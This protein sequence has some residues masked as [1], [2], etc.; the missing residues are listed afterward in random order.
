M[1]LSRTTKKPDARDRTIGGG[2]GEEGAAAAAAGGREEKYTTRGTILSHALGLEGNT[3]SLTP[4]IRSLSS[5]DRCPSPSP[6]LTHTS[7]MATQNTQ[8]LAPDSASTADYREL[9]HS[10]LV[11]PSC[12]YTLLQDVLTSREGLASD[13]ECLFTATSVTALSGTQPEGHCDSYVTLADSLASLSVPCEAKMQDLAREAKGEQW[14][15]T[16]QTT[17]YCRV[18]DGV[19]P[20]LHLVT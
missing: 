4:S 6:F 14:E 17:G 5:L 11:E 12:A 3:A 1:F 9:E 10:S 20:T 7:S 2:G 8:T 15:G 19:T 16:Q 13:G 18:D